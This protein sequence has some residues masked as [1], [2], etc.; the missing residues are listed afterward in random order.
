MNQDSAPSP[1]TVSSSHPAEPHFILLSQQQRIGLM[2]IWCLGFGLALWALGMAVVH[3]DSPLGWGVSGVMV[4]LWL[5]LGAVA[6]RQGIQP[7][8]T[9]C[10]QQLA[11]VEEDAAALRSQLTTE[12]LA[13]TTLLQEVQ[14]RE[15][16]FRRQYEKLPIPVCTWRYTGD[17]FIFV[18]CNEAAIALTRGEVLNNMG[19]RATEVLTQ[20]PH[21]YNDLIDCILHQTPVARSLHLPAADVHLQLRYLFIPPNWVMVL[22]E[23][24]TSQHRSETQLKLRLRQQSALATLGQRGLTASDLD[25]LINDLVNLVARTLRVKYCAIFEQLNDH[26]L[27]LRAGVGWKPGLVGQI[28][29]SATETSQSGYT[30][31]QGQPV[32]VLDLRLE[33]RFRGEVLL[34]NHRIISGVSVVVLGVDHPYGVLGIYSDRPREFNHDDA[35]FLQAVGHILTTAIKR[36]QQAAQLHLMKRAIDSSSNSIVISDAIAIDHPI[37]YAN[38]SFET[39]TGYHAPDIIGESISLLYG[40]ETNPQTLR[41]INHAR[42]QGQDFH[43]TLRYYRKDGTPFWMELN[44]APVHDPHGAL[45]HFIEVQTDITER[46]Q[47]EETL[48][49]E[50][51][52]LNGIL[53]TS[54]AA[55]IVI[56]REGQLTFANER[57]EAILGLTHQAQKRTKNRLTWYHNHAQTSPLPLKDLPIGPI[58][59]EGEPIFDLRYTWITGENSL[60]TGRSERQYLSINGSPLRDS[61]GTITAAVLSITDITEQ[62][63]AEIALRQS[64]EQFRLLFELAPIGIFLCDLDGRFQKVN[65][66]LCSVLGY[67]ATQL[68]QTHLIDLTHPDDRAADLAINQKLLL[69]EINQFQVEKRF[70]SQQNLIAHALVRVVVVYDDEGKPSHEIGQLVDISDRKR[71]EEA[72]RASEKRLEGILGSIAD[73][74]WSADP[75]TLNPIYFNPAAAQVF[76]R[77]LPE[78]FATPRL[79]LTL[80]HPE[81]QNRFTQHLRLLSETSAG[82]CE[83]RIVRPDGELRWLACR[84]RMVYDDQNQPLRIDGISSDITERRRAEAQL[85]RNAF[86]D[87]LTELPNRALFMDR[88]WHTIRRAK[89]RGGY[90]FA[91]LFLDID[92]FKLINDSLGHTVGD[93]LLVAIA[94]RLEDYLRPSDTLARLGGD[95]FTILLEEIRDRQEA[96]AI[97]DR[98]HIA[99]RASFHIQSYD[100]FAETSIGIAFSQ[101]SDTDLNQIHY[102]YPEDIL[103]DADTAMYRAK[104]LGK[105]RY[106]V[107]HPAMHQRALARLELET[108]LRRAVERG[109]FVAHYQPIM[110]LK[111][112]K[113]SGFEALIRWQHPDKGLVAPAHFIAIAEETGLI[114][115]MGEWIL[116]TATQQMK[117]WQQQYH[118]A[119]DVVINVN[120]SGR[121]MNELGLL[122]MITQ[123][124]EDTQL[125][126]HHLKLEITESM[127]MN[128]ATEAKSILMAL[129]SHQI[130]LGIDDFGTGYSSLSYLDQFPVNTLKIDR[131]FVMRMKANGEDSEIVQAIINLA[132]ILGMDVV[133]EGIDA[134]MQ[135][136][137]LKRWGCD[138]GQG[139][140]FAKP[141]PPQAAGE[142]L[143]RHL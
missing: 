26:A 51:D 106:A 137:Y 10:I 6:P 28:T 124:L 134:P 98:I 126:P 129:R 100:V 7:Y 113:I 123:I 88:L 50:R 105:G 89:R 58:L 4:L 54:I 30:L 77:S 32:V 92:S 93:E 42:F 48:R 71:A 85:R 23:D 67:T 29:V 18:G 97:A 5:A 75:H 16:Q 118:K 115:P 101:L 52:L 20:D 94:R 74:V 60:R 61:Q 49:N 140:Y 68:H 104:A 116:A 91:V 78:L 2:G 99:L 12:M 139:Y 122:D 108:D 21:I 13:Y 25:G 39:L 31:V 120:L 3:A 80:I 127:L 121:Q 19:K 83:Y 14:E 82:E 117:T 44:L 119:T 62:Y 72:L 65:P 103:R 36:E 125:A 76:G 57:A 53:Q 135:V 59:S 96:L 8:P 17:N 41:A 66:A 141:L 136:A 15:M 132:H 55:I 64:E 73:V 107:F 37:L 112:G 40:P 43:G 95:E 33:T 27:L 81:D 56:N 1:P 63:N 142:F 11:G 131:S 79:W 109:E 130:Q 86:Y 102:D 38:S 69:G 143:S 45:T 138:Y 46:K 35:Q 47:F 111:S 128:N 90:L 9:E 114:V 87:S 22:T 34:H 24:I 70:I 110:N 133:A 84:S